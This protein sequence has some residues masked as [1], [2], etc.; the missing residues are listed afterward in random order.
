[1]KQLQSCPAHLGGVKVL[2]VN[3]SNKF[4][5]TFAIIGVSLVLGVQSPVLAQEVGGA[6]HYT[7]EQAEMG[8]TVFLQNCSGCHGYTMI[9]VV[10]GFSNMDQ[11]YSLISL[12]MPW[13]DAGSL[14]DDDYL[15]IVAYLLRENDVESSD[16][17]LT[18][19]RD[20]LRSISLS[21]TKLD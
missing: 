9:D 20:L 12:T 18:A 6:G 10:K 3:I 14:A 2:A 1:L 17:K 8:E 19:D 13:E 11:F 7:K 15:S 16:Q 5:N 21:D 4:T